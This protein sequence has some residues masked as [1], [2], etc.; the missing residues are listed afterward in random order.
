M[1]MIRE[2][3]DKYSPV[4]GDLQLQNFLIY[5]NRLQ[6]IQQKMSEWKPETFLELS[7]RP[8]KNPLPFYGF[9]FAIVIGIASILALVAT[10]IQTYA[11]LKELELQ[12]QELNGP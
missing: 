9:W 6:Y 5:A 4:Q 1:D 3:R 7:V 12:I 10:I 8:Y 11:T 2:F